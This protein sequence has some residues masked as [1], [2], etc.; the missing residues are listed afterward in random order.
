M[1]DVHTDGLNVYPDRSIDRSSGRASACTAWRNEVGLGFYRGTMEKV[2]TK[3]LVTLAVLFAFCVKG[4]VCG[5]GTSTSIAN[6]TV[7]SF[8]VDCALC[9]LGTIDSWAARLRVFE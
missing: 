9:D 4:S 8:N 7:M 3:A 6:V 5:G 2:A 1:C